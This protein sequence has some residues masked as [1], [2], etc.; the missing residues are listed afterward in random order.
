VSDKRVLVIGDV[1]VDRYVYV[2]STRTAEEAK[3]PVWDEVSVEPRPGGAGNVA[4][5]LVSMDLDV[6][7]CGIGPR[8]TDWCF[9]GIDTSLCTGGETMYK[10]RY[11]DVGCDPKILFR[12]DNMKRFSQKAIDEFR[13]AF[14]IKS[15]RAQPFDAVIISDYDK[16]TVIPEV[17]RFALKSPIVIVDSKRE[18]L[19][20]FDGASVLKVNEKEFS[21]QASSKLYPNVTAFFDYVV[22]TKGA[23]GADLLQF[24]R[25]A[26]DGNRYVT[27][28]ESFEAK[29]V[30]AVDVTGCGDTHTAAMAC[31]LLRGGDMRAAVKFANDCASSVVQRF[32]TSTV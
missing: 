12:L 7:L 28:K 30:R 3:I 11:V 2:Q 6:W 10:T 17:I 32:G 25:F 26:S 23:A 20:I 24:D 15:E 16:G 14:D 27:H 8:S 29:K 5:N 22:V 19:S 13:I 31:A 21:A 9:S 1:M 4:Y 18:D